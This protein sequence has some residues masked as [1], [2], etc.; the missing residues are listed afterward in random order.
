MREA[1]WQA[2][3]EYSGFDDLKEYVTSGRLVLLVSVRYGSP[4]EASTIIRSQGLRLSALAHNRLSPLEEQ[5][6]KI[7]DQ[8]WGLAD[9]PVILEPRD[10]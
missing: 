7:R 1:K 3:I 9:V 4:R 2:R 5:S 8:L 6:V 10:V